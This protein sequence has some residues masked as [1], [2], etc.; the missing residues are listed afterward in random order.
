MCRR[1]RLPIR[2]LICRPPTQTRRLTRLRLPT[3]L[4]TATDDRDC[5]PSTEV[6]IEILLDGN[7]VVHLVD[8]EDLRVAAVA[9]ELV[10]LAHDERL[11]RLGRADFRAQAAEAAAR[12]VEVEV[13]EDLDLLPGSR[14]PPSAIR[15]SGHALAHWSQTMQVCAPVAGSVCSRRTPRKRGAV[16]R[17]SA[18]YW[19]VN[20][21]CGVYFSVSHSPSAGRRGRSS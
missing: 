14:W 16:G 8:A 18:G 4:P 3:D 13:V 15:S 7:A 20:A 9:A 12:Q 5:R 21:G 6:S 1:H 19:N 17:R 11:D 10:V 2:P